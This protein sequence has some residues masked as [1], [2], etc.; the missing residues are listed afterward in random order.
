MAKQSVFAGVSFLVFAGSGLLMVRKHDSLPDAFTSEHV[1]WP[2]H[3]FVSK[4]EG[5]QAN[6]ST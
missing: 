6:G 4:A 3:L 2:L 1:S 5:H